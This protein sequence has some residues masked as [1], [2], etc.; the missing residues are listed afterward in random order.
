M[1]VALLIVGQ[2]EYN[3]AITMHAESL[4][5]TV[6]FMAAKGCDG[7]IFSLVEQLMHAGIVSVSKP[8]RTLEDGG[9]ILM[10]RDFW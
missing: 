3:S 4:P 10:R 1:A 2:A 8:G 6:D 7:M 5:V 9:D